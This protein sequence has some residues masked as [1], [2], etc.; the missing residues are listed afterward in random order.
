MSKV[1]EAVARLRRIAAGEYEDDVYVEFLEEHPSFSLIQA[2]VADRV[3]TSNAYLAEHPAD[4][5]REFDL[6]WVQ[7]MYCGQLYRDEISTLLVCQIGRG[8]EIDEHGAVHIDHS[9]MKPVKT[10]GDVRRLCSALGIE[11]KQPE[12][13][14]LE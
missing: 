10:R 4:D 14:A 11:L 2:M 1:Q 7:D 9:E 3:W 6:D 8:V 13:V 12:P 5:S